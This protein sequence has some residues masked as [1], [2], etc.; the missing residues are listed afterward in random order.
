MPII[1][2]DS[3]AIPQPVPFWV[4]ENAVWVLLVVPL[5]GKVKLSLAM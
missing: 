2:F 5:K 4:A 1:P 3:A